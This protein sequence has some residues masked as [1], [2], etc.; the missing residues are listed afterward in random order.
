[1]PSYKE[2]LYMEKKENREGLVN[3]NQ[4]FDD[5]NL[6]KNINSFFNI[7]KVYLLIIHNDHLFKILCNIKS[8]FFTNDFV[9]ID[10]L[11]N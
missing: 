8:K 1:M 9:K 3:S 5:E 7:E 6:I 4:I 11:N 10:L 2:K